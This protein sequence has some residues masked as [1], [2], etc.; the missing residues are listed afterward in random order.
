MPVT[1]GE[2]ASHYVGRAYVRA[3]VRAGGTPLVLPSVDEDADAV[4]DATLE[5]LDGL[6]LSGGC[7]LSPEL[8]GGPPGAAL[9][10]D[11]VRD[12][13]ELA[14]LAGARERGIPVLG[15]CRGMEL[16]NV[17]YGGTL[18]DGAEHPAAQDARSP[19]LG[20]MRVHHVGV[21]PETLAREVFGLSEVDA[22]C[23]HHQA[24]ARIGEGLVASVVAA[25]GSVEAVED[26]ES[27][28]L[29]IIWHPELGLDR[30]PTHQLVYDWVVREARRP[31]PTGVPA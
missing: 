31:A 13:F 2:L 10:A 8:Y 5:L 27:R 6:V 17:A 14:L 28:V 21:V 25:D 16:I 3:V 23:V 24:P 29:G 12:R 19:E 15:I 1:E 9:D 22:T 4:A 26:R 18:R 20:P 30:A 11:P 7:D